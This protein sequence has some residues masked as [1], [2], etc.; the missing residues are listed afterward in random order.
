MLNIFKW[1]K[2]DKKTRKKIM[3]RAMF[4]ITSIRSY[5]AEWIETIKIEGDEG[6][7]RYTRQF[8]NKDFDLKN[9]KVKKSDIENAYKS[10]DPKIVEIIKRQISISRENAQS[11]ARQETVLKSFIPGVSVGYKITPI[12]SVGIAVPA[13]QVP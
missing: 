13:G 2:T 11:K 7:L 10:V 9:L 4:D 12:E 3:A 6:I 5:V 1:S 8:D